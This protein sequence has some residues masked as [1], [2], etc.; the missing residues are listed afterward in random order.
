MLKEMT[1]KKYLLMTTLLVHTG[2]AVFATTAEEFF[3]EGLESSTN[4]GVDVRKGTI[5]ALIENALYLDVHLKNGV[6]DEKTLSSIKDI[7]DSIAGVKAVGVFE[8]FPA[9]DWFQYEVKPGNMMVGVLY[10][11]QF[12]DQMTAELQQKLV[13]LP[14]TTSPLLRAEIAKLI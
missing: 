8:V 2:T 13:L 6:S 10:L 7:R 3:P 11:Q 1:M 9:I 4:N 5:K 12:P 14:K